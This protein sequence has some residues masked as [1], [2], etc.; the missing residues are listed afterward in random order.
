VVLHRCRIVE[1]GT[2]QMLVQRDGHYAR[3]Y[4]AQFA[5]K[6]K[7]PTAHAVP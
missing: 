1:T 3:L 7:E 2:H 6:E 5:G 4:R